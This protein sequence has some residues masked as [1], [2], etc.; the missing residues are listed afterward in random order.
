MVELKRLTIH[1]YRNMEHASSSLAT[2]GTS[3]SA[4][5][6]RNPFSRACDNPGSPC[7]WVVP[8]GIL[9]GPKIGLPEGTTDDSM[10]DEQLAFLSEVVRLLDL[11]SATALAAARPA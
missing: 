5:H 4:K 3:C 1:R 8:V 2:A 7:T 10:K 9:E 11:R 6:P